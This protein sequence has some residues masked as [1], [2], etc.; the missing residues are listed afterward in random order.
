MRI[1][2]MFVENA[3]QKEGFDAFFKGVTVDLNPYEVFSDKST[4]WDIGWKVAHSYFKYFIP[5][6]NYLPA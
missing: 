5:A 2:I 3:L 4:Q 1:Y 6:A